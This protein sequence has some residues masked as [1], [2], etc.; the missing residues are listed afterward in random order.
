MATIVGAAGGGTWDAATTTTWVGGVAPTAADDVQLTGTTGAITI[1]S[2]AVCRS[3]DCTG[4]TNTLTHT[5]AVTL[6]IGDGTAGTGN[7]A[8]TLVSGMT[9]TLGST[10]TSAI[11][12]LS[13][14]ATQQ[15]LTFGTKIV[16][17]ITFNGVAG[18]WIL[19]DTLAS[20]AVGVLGYYSASVTLTNGTL[21]TNGQ[22]V[23]CVSFTSIGSATR[24]LTLGASTIRFRTWDLTAT[25]MTF[26]GAS[27]TLIWR[28]INAAQS[29]TFNGAGL[30]YGAI[31]VYA[32]GNA[33]AMNMSGSNTFSSF[34]A[35]AVA[36]GF[37]TNRSITFNN[38][39]TQTFT[40]ADISGLESGYYLKINCPG[41]ASTHTLTISGGGPVTAKWV[42]VAQSI[43]TP[44]GTWIATQ[45]VNRNSEGG[46]GSG[47]IFSDLGTRSV[48]NK[49]FR[50][51]IFTPGRPR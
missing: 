36:D 32:G 26:S 38:G 13:T 37:G 15:S 51:A 11:T 6:N 49:K 40:S 35:R 45:S 42:S 31:E 39:T 27:S 17:N 8:L 25:G 3:L 4:Y 46:I 7:K 22:T 20:T 16:G 30:T 18:S 34:Y 19:N 43:A 5:A 2:G 1:A 23:N 33:S 28:E 41:A 44:A 24:V 21:D 9:Y 48:F 47:W 50:P 29:P 14:S 12:F 10:S